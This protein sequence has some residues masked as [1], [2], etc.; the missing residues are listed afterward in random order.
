MSTGDRSAEGRGAP[1]RRYEVIAV[2]AGRGV[3][4]R[5]AAVLLGVSESGY[6]AWRRR[7]PSARSLR[8]AWLTRVILDIHT[9]S[10]AVFG[11]R[12]IRQELSRRYGISVSHA[13]V[14]FLMERAGIRGRPGRLCDAQSLPDAGRGQRWVVD[15]NACASPDGTVY[16]AVVLEAT[17]HRLVGWST[18]SRASGLLVQLALG[19][20]IA[21]EAV[22][23]PASYARGGGPAVCAFTGRA[24]A[25]R[26][27]PATGV[28]GDGYDHA[29]AEVFWRELHDHLGDLG[30]GKNPQMHEERLLEAF[31]RFARHAAPTAG[32]VGAAST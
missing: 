22:A 14:E 29:V 24:H 25:L 5:K 9:S 32:A 12:R 15:V 1:K 28:V 16:A 6:Y 4:A 8:H 27:S 30:W 2:L 19:E 23:P 21:R 7:G 31:E 10:G 13:T 20:A 11:Y 26:Q 17:S 18:G 3:A